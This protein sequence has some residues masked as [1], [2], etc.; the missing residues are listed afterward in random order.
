MGSGG[1]D[2]KFHKNRFR[3]SKKLIG[4]DIQTAK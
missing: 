1:H 2:I 4:K 3:H